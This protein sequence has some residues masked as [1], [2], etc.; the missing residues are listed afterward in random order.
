MSYSRAG[1]GT[2][3]F[4]ARSVPDLSFYCLAINLNTPT[5]ITNTNHSLN[6][7]NKKISF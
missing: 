5:S 7:T 4:L 3:P 6:F 2:V 1:D